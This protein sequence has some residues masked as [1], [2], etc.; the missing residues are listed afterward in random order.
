MKTITKVMAEGDVALTYHLGR[1]GNDYFIT[2][3]GGQEHVGTV[4]LAVPRPSLENPDYLSSTSSVLNVTGHKDE[5]VARP[6]AEYLARTLNARVVVAA[7]IHYGQATKQLIEQ[8]MKLARQ[9]LKEMPLW[10]AEL[11]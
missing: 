2:V 8:V 9:A 7:G 1:L 4:V 6:L 10:L 11:A 3:T 5:E